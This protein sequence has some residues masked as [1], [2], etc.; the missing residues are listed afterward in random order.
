[1]K[2][3][4]KIT[5]VD[6]EV[7]Q[8]YEFEPVEDTVELREVKDGYE[9]RYLTLDNE[10]VLPNEWQNES[11]FLVNYHC[12]F[13]VESG[14]CAKNV[15]GY[16]YTGNET[17]YDREGA[18]AL[19]KEYYCLPIDSYIHSGVRLSLAGG[20]AGRLPQGHEQFD[21]S[22]VGAILVSKAVFKTKKRA[23]EAAEGLVTEWNMLLSGDVYRLVSEKLDR[24]KKRIDYDIVCGYAGYDYAKDA[25]KTEI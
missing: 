18:E 21:V 11:L 19:L 5:Y 12:N 10:P 15:L 20:F 9:L 14:I 22:R 13:W 17:E 6:I 8:E 3:Q 4:K 1:M 16:I 2:I 24:D 23:E 25:L 7:R